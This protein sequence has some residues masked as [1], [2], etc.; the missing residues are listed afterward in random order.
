MKG[1]RCQIFPSL[2]E[3]PEAGKVV[4]CFICKSGCHTESCSKMLYRT[5]V[6]AKRVQVRVCNFCSNQ[7]PDRFSPTP[8]REAITNSGNGPYGRIYR[9]R[10]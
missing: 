4:L 9:T 5:D 3:G 1:I 7:M 10:S 8:P 6:R 2:Q